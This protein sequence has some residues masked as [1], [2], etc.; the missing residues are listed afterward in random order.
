MALV[1]SACNY[2]EQNDLKSA[3]HNWS[4]EWHRTN[5]HNSLYGTI[6]IS[7]FKEEEFDFTFEGI[8]QA[9]MG[10]ISG[11]AVLVD[12]NTGI[13]NYKSEVNDDIFAKLEFVLNGEALLVKLLEGDNSAFAMGH[14]VYPD[15]EY[16]KSEPVYTNANIVDDILPT[17]KLKDQMKSLLGGDR[18]E[19]MIQV[20]ELGSRN[21]RGLTYS[22]FISG[23]GQGVDLLIKEDK[24]YCL[25]YLAGE[26]YTLYTNDEMYKESLPSFMKIDRDE[27]Y[28]LNFIYKPVK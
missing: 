27:G 13:C 10:K 20:M 25:S 15:G 21:D 6:I 4:G 28:E 2:Q 7:N 11:T 24:I 19:Q 16:T 23:A 3:A 22:G 17:D 9:N 8:Y 1:L 14:N 12:K 26:G 18:Y 5:I